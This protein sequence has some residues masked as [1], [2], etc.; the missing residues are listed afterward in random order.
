[1]CDSPRVTDTPKG[2]SQILTC[3]PQISGPLSM[4]QM[5]MADP[6]AVSSAQLCPMDL[7]LNVWVFLLQ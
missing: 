1:M 7:G 3:V 4:D 5:A 6:A 2:V